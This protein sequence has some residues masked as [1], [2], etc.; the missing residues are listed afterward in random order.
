[1]HVLSQS[2]YSNKQPC[3]RKAPACTSSE[4]Q[5]QIAEARESLNGQKKM[6]TRKK[7]SRTRRAP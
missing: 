6:A 3:V 4:T 7:H 1:M 5:G 2:V